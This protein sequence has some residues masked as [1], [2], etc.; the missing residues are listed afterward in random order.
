RHADDLS[1]RKG[2]FLAA[3]SH[4][5]RTPANAVNLLAELLRKSAHD[6]SQTDEIPEVAEELERTCSSL[7]A[8]VSNGIEL[9]RLDLGAAELNETEI[10]LGTWMEEQCRRYQPLAEEKK[11][12]FNCGTPDAK[13]R[14]RIDKI[15]LSRLLGI[16]VDNA[17][18]FTERG[19]VSVEAHLTENNALRFDV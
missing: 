19:Q 14:A 1:S 15:R 16:L 10:E 12:E 4:D 8:L 18:K 7:V 5:L 3:L 2:R 6:P 11:L 13:I 17:I 9:T